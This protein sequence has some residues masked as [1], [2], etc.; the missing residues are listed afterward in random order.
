MADLLQ[1]R[2]LR[3]IK[4]IKE[5][6]SRALRNGLIA[7]GAGVSID[8]DPEV[9]GRLKVQEGSWFELPAGVQSFG[10]HCVRDAAWD[11]YLLDADDCGNLGRLLESELGTWVPG[12]ETGSGHK[13][14]PYTSKFLIL[15]G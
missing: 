12:R 14:A 8:K 10:G 15:S 3:P 6:V 2:C 13:L 4:G 5:A 1:V 7:A 9:V 11:L